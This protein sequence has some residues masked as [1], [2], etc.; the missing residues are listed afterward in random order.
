MVREEY[1]RSIK[2]WAK[3]ARKEQ[4]FVTSEILQRAAKSISLQTSALF[5]D[6]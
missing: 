5:S 6:S 1:E 2:E 3:K 4:M